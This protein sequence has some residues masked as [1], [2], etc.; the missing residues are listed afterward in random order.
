MDNYFQILIYLIIIFAVLNSLFKKKDK[1]ETGKRPGPSASSP[2]SGYPSENTERK[3]QEE[4]DILKE[5]EGLFKEEKTRTSDIRNRKSEIEKAEMRKVPAEE[6]MKDAEWHSE[7][8]EWH[9]EDEEWHSE[10]KEWHEKSAAEHKL[11]Q[12]WHSITQFKRIPKID[13]TIEKEAE[14][15]EHM[16]ESIHEEGNFSFRE[17]TERLYSPQS[18]KEFIIFSE[19]IGKPKYL[20]R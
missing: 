1:A 8:K 19:I 12:S 7:D 13:K 16:L 20:R 17:L 15:F 10:D 2:S 11:D 3:K 6:H 5:I 9:S 18:L 4:Y 14:K